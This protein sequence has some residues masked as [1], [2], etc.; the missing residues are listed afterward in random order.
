MSESVADWH[1]LEDVHPE[2]TAFPVRSRAG[3]EPILVFATGNRQFRGVQRACPHLK[4]SLQDAQ[5]MNG[6][7]MLR[8]AKHNF[9]FKLADGKGVNCP[10][11]K[12]KVFEIKEEDM[13]LLARPVS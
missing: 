3:T 12:I 9:V 7:T 11:F 4:E 10:G 1:I 8:C 2:T 6:N 13:R 5:L